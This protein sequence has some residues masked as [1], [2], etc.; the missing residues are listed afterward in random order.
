MSN[1]VWLVSLFD[2][3]FKCVHMLST[4]WLWPFDRQKLGPRFLFLLPT[5]HYFDMF[6]EFLDWNFPRTWLF[7]FFFMQWKQLS[8]LVYWRQKTHRFHV[9]CCEMLINQ[10]DLFTVNVNSCRLVTMWL[11]ITF[12][13]LKKKTT[14][15]KL[16]YYY[17]SD[18]KIFSEFT[19]WHLGFC[20]LF[21]YF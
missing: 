19:I 8:C 17:V 14:K 4:D 13:D 12:T 1:V 6:C 2:L 9:S 20:F 11:V 5:G 10:S 3:Y 18:I 7:L 15:P 21:P 16:V